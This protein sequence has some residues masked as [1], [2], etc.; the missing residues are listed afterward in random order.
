MKKLAI[1]KRRN[2][3]IDFLKLFFMFMVVGVH[4]EYIFGK[5]LYF[6]SGALAVEFFFIVSGYLMAKYTDEINIKAD[7]L[8]VK[9]NIAQETIKFVFHKYKIIFLPL[10]VSIVACVAIRYFFGEAK[11]IQ[12]N[13][14]NST[15]ELLCGQ[16]YGFSA[17]LSTGVSWYLSAMFAAMWI[18]FPLYLKKRETFSYIIAPLLVLF[19]LGWIS[20][21]YGNI[22]EATGLWTGFY[23]KGMLRG[24]AEVSAGVIC[25]EIVKKMLKLN[26]TKF[27][28]IFL[29]I[30]ELSCYLISSLYMLLHLPSG[31][32]TI[33]ILLLMI[34]I[35]ITFSEQSLTTRLFKSSK[36]SYC[37]SFSGV[38]LFCNLTWGVIMRNKMI[39]HTPKE[40]ALVFVALSI[41]TTVLVL[42]IIKIIQIIAKK[43]NDKIKLTYPNNKKL[44]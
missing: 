35:S 15:W 22:T 18:L 26:W 14:I 9:L 36:W 34:A 2:Y 44:A 37:A 31:Q 25:Y 6:L 38:L 16:M 39:D 24:I 43:L 13:I 10:L 12:N 19:L 40:R 17:Y 32:D 33:I 28:H 41:I 23:F 21:T 8:K 4:S 42:I 7:K 5:K 1:N 20:Y 27:G 30:V 11:D 29:T 3:V